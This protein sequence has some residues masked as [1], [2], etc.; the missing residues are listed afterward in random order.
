MEDTS[1]PEHS[2]LGAAW[3]YRWQ[4]L[5]TIIAFAGLAFA[6]STLRAESWMAT[7]S[8]VVEEPG[9]QQLYSS[10]N[11]TDPERYL[12]D[13]VAI[14]QSAE[15]ADQAA[16]LDGNIKTAARKLMPDILPD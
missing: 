2:L 5:A 14:L 13:Q 3:R 9:I 10:D 1:T 16:K 8:L 7:A 6:Y 4:V 11:P 15:I 12:Q